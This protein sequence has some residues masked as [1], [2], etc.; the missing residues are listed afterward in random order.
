MTPMHPSI[1]PLATLSF[2]VTLGCNQRDDSPAQ[3]RSVPRGPQSPA[4]R[5]DP[6]TAHRGDSVAGLEMDSVQTQRTPSGE[7]IGTVRFTGSL[8]I[9]GR[10][11][12]HPDGDDYPFPCFEADSGSG[13]RLPRWA[14]DERR[15]WFCFEN[16]VDARTRFG[17]P[18]PDRPATI[19][20]DRF[21]INRNLSDAV[22]SARLVDVVSLATSE[23]RCFT[24][25][26]SVLS[27]RPGTVVPGPPGLTGWLTL[28]RLA[29]PGA[30]S[31]TARLVDSD[32]RA[33]GAMW[34]RIS[35]DSIR[36]V[37]FDDFLRVEM[38]LASTGAALTGLA[39]ATS[40]A[41]LAPDS[42]GRRAPYRREWRIVGR[43]TPCGSGPP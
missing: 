34:H 9:D 32:R 31:G 18:A 5:F 33:L 10:T 39:V 20:I 27:R 19:R 11:F 16:H 37:G 21:T 4:N 14:G 38:R 29:A 17:G 35:G 28:D 2:L 36:L 1:R 25:S 13:H 8:L 41:A 7:W 24:T 43:Q 26:G 15:P 3:G 42:S 40:D 23:T 22:N 12:R 6:A 30:D